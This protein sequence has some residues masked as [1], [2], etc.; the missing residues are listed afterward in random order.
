MTGQAKGLDLVEA[1]LEREF[2]RCDDLNVGC[3][4]HVQP[5]TSFRRSMYFCGDATC[6]A[7]YVGQTRT[8]CVFGRGCNRHGQCYKPPHQRPGRKGA[9]KQCNGNIMGSS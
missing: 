3:G 5:R 9:N 6:V 1:Y 8:V 7:V 4:C 2:A